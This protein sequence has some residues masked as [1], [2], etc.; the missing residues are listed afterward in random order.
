MNSSIN[1]ISGPI[2]GTGNNLK[3]YDS[4]TG[5][6]AG[7]GVDKSQFQAAFASF[8]KQ[9]LIREKIDQ[10]DIFKLNDTEFKDKY[11]LTQKEL[12]NKVQD[13]FEIQLAKNVK[14]EVERKQQ[15]QSETREK[16]IRIIMSQTTY[17]HHIAE[18]KYDAYM[19]DYEAVIRNYLSGDCDN[20]DNDD[21]D[22]DD[23]DDDNSD[24][25]KNNS[26]LSINQQIYT[27]IRNFMDYGPQ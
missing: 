22:G 8:I 24:N 27:H 26:S 1:N 12:Q 25:Q 18:T 14:C 11:A 10:L 3:Q 13:D 5:V 20:D 6:G 7:V 16:H 9:Y 23:G 2:N 21:N 19:Q 4:E 15:K 17:N